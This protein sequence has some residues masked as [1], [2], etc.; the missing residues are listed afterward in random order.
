MFYVS[1]L[2]LANLETLLQHNFCYKLEEEN[3][4]K[5]KKILQH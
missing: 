2:E 4:F 3:K 5:V 1:L